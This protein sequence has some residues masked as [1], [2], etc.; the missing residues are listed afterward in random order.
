MA[1]QAARPSRRSTEEIRTLIL[2]AAHQLFDTQGYAATTTSQ[3]ARRA[4]VSERLLFTNFGSKA[5][6]FEATVVAPFSEWIAS[7]MQSWDIDEPG[8]HEESIRRFV[9]GFFDL[10][11]RNRKI[12][13]SMIAAIDHESGGLHGAALAIRRQ[14]A[15]GLGRM[16]R[17]VATASSDVAGLDPPASIAVAAGAVLAAAVLDEWLSPAEGNRPDDDQLVQELTLM[18]NYGILRRPTNAPAQNAGT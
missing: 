10:A 3:I 5:Q 9:V 14:I 11:R 2:D 7:Y 17:L 12:L 13:L 4:Q 1:S 18:L 15:D 16:Q 8:G 6:L